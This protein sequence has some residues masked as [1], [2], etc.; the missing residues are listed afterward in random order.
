MTQTTRVCVVFTALSLLSTIVS[1]AEPP[2]TKNRSA[3][4]GLNV[5]S[6]AFPTEGMIPSKHSCESGD[7]SPP[8]AWSGAPAGTKSFALI[9]DDPDAPGG[10]WVHWVVYN[11]PANATAMAEK[12]AAAPN[13]PNGARQG[14]ND[15][16]KIGYGGPCPPAGKAHHY[17]FKLYALDTELPLKPGATKKDVEQAME[18]HILAEAMLMGKYQRKK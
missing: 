17:F 11:L 14:A 1:N 8:L 3:S 5:I 12:I 4:V 9:C 10:T 7:I 18:H 6:P 15:F 2:A 13:L 16:G